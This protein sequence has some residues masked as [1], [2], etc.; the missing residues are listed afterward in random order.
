M[1]DLSN[2]EGVLR[3]MWDVRANKAQLTPE[4]ART[5]QKAAWQAAR[6][7]LGINAKAKP[8]AAADDDED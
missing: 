6:K 5:R 3:E 1:A 7:I 8:A 4:Q 2:A